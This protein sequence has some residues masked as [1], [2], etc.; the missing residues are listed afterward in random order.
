MTKKL[1]RQ[2]EQDSEEQDSDRDRDKK[3]LQIMSPPL[4]TKPYDFN[5]QDS[6][7]DTN[8]SK[9]NNAQ[10]YLITTIRGRNAMRKRLV[11]TIVPSLNVSN[12]V[13]PW[14]AYYQVGTCQQSKIQV[15]A[16]QAKKRA[17]L[18]RD[19]K[20]A[21]EPQAEASKSSAPQPVRRILTSKCIEGN[22]SSLAHKMEQS[23]T[24]SMSG[25]TQPRLA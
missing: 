8:N 24:R 13:M 7:A 22:I 10:S 15:L 3:N 1:Y 5:A 17:R 20:D 14:W 21:K 25:D 6:T 23:D 16:S 2:Y 4:S 18:L 12:N 11:G 19:H 9:D